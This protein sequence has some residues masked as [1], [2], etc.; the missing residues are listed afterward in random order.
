MKGNTMKKLVALIAV[1]G[2]LAAGCSTNKEN[3]G[4]ASDQRDTG[5]GTGSSQEDENLESSPK[6]DAGNGGTDSS[7]ITNNSNSD[8][9]GSPP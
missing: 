9:G 5:Y 8:A 3:Q 6:M 2:L 7:A 1:T 4:G